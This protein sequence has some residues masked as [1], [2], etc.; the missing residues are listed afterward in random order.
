MTRANKHLAS[1]KLVLPTALF[2]V[3]ACGDPLKLPQLIEENRVLGARVEVLGDA[4]RA[5]PAPGETATVRFLVADPHERRPLSWAFSICE[6][7]A[8]SRGTPVCHA[9]PFAATQSG[10]PALAEPTFQFTLPGEA[11]LR[12][13]PRIALLGVICAD[14]TAR[15]GSSFG[16]TVCVGEGAQKTYVN[17]DIRI[18]RGEESN[19]NPS[20]TDLG[21]R[22]DGQAWPAA[23]PA[24]LEQ[25]DCMDLPSDVPIVTPASGD[26][27]L[28]I[29]PTE[30]MREPLVVSNPLDPPRETLM[31]SHY[32][33][34]GELDGPYSVIDAEQGIAPITVAWQAPATAP[35]AGLLVRFY[36]VAR[37]LRGGA[38]WTVR[39]LCVQP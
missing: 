30:R 13:A 27:L 36:V 33:T 28:E 3:A 39:A 14:G 34:A 7:E 25:T 17:L 23:D 2:V 21:V 31:L 37:D 8:V 6:A 5:S 16:D 22:L 38:D 29:E 20:F 24:T 19:D 12:D 32:A 26:H 10:A 9:P 18:A 35:A 15:M 11:E 4:D 1:L